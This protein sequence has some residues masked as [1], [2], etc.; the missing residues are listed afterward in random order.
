MNK[1]L[2]TWV[3]I[4]LL[5]IGGIMIVKN[6]GDESS[7][8]EIDSGAQSAAPGVN[9]EIVPP[10]S[11]STPVIVKAFTVNG[12]NFSFTPST[13]TVNKGDTVRIT[14]VNQNGMHDWRL[15]EFN[16]NTSVIQ[17]GQ[18]ETIEFV[19]DK[20]GSFEYYCSVGQHRQNG[21]KGTL[22]VQ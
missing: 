15:D 8:V 10:V 12:S 22:V 16:A 4:V 18:S 19:A 3:I 6:T 1:T 21:M 9:T 5:V 7:R 11:T 20:T 2:I 17:G 13:M 14:F